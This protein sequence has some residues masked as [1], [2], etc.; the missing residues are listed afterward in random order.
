MSET[1]GAHRLSRAADGFA[2]WHP[3]VNL[4]FFVLV[5]TCGMFL[6]HPVC[7]GLS[8]VCATAYAIRLNG[9]TA[10]RFGLR[11]LLPVLLVTALLNPAF[12]HEGVTVLGYLPSGN[13]LTLESVLYGAAAALM[14]VTVVS[15]FSCF[16]T[17]MTSD[18]LVYLFGRVVP[19]LSL[20]LSL[21]LRLVPRYRAQIRVIADAQRCVGRDVSQGSVLAR[22]RQGARMLSVMVT[23]ALENAIGTADS[24]RARGF[25]LAGRTAFSAYRVRRRDLAALVFLLACGGCLLVGTLLGGLRFLYFPV[26]G[27]APVGPLTLGLFAAYLALCALPLAIDLQEDYR[28]KR[29]RSSI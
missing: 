20:I 25:G 9:R 16:N 28:W 21:S 29:S 27:G 7:L 5:V 4:L 3:A 15:W 19:A 13:P 6:M 8:F 12:N 17:V 1:A 22:A 23:W 26:V 14:L 18:K 24:M 2:A 10:L 11:F